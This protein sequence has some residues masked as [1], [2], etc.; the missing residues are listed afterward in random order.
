V[1]IQRIAVDR[2]MGRKFDIQVT[3]PCLCLCGPIGAGK[4]TVLH[5]VHLVL[6]LPTA[7][8]ERNLDRLSPSGAWSAALDFADG[9]VRQIRRAQRGA[10]GTYEVNGRAVAKTVWLDAVKQV[11]DVEPHHVSLDAFLGLSGQK[12]AALFAQLLEGGGAARACLGDVAQGVENRDLEPLVRSLVDEDEKA[13]SDLMRS[14]QPIV[15]TPAEVGEAMRQL[16]A[17]LAQRE[18]DARIH[19]DQLI[20]SRTSTQGQ[21]PADLQRLIAA[22]DEQLGKVKGEKGNLERDR[23]RSQSAH[24]VL[25]TAEKTLEKTKVELA[26]NR[27]IVEQAATRRSHVEAAE[28][29]HAALESELKAL[30][31]RVVPTSEA[32]RACQS[33]IDLLS[34]NQRIV[35]D[36]LALEWKVADDWI[37]AQAEEMLAAADVVQIQAVP[38]TESLIAF[39]RE[40]V[41]EVFGGSVEKIDEAIKEEQGRLEEA[42]A[43]NTALAQDLEAKRKSID[44]AA[45]DRKKAGKEVEELEQAEK[46]VVDL[47]KQVAER[48]DERAQLEKKVAETAVPSDEGVLDAQLEQV[49]GERDRLARLLRDA[50][51]A[52]ALSGQVENQRVEVERL[53]LMGTAAKRLVEMVHEWRNRIVTEQ[54]A[55]VMQPFRD[56][57]ETVWGQDMQVAHHSSGTGRSTEFEFTIDRGGAQV[58]LDLLSDGETTLTGAAF[59]TA[60]QRIHNG[61]GSILTMNTEALDAEGLVRLLQAAPDLGL[62]FVALANNRVR[63]DLSDMPIGLHG[64]EEVYGQWQFVDLG[65]SAKV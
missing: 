64:A 2:L 58:P 37:Y 31:D 49:K 1:N 46:A 10:K 35:S 3:K 53:E 11:L 16:S 48:E 61:V 20:D 23:E 17:H 4:S 36:L 42:E 33:K 60:L 19:L 29:T 38:P 14:L 63:E 45:T 6:G 27:A 15:G 43:E 39:A 26:R 50:E 21:S 24:D 54:V 34:A 40:V 30:T 18:R 22:Q 8:G 59:L 47:E 9:D 55:D 57:F 52:L 51:E 44:A 32:W 25:K 13:T 62:D 12:R 41:T 7:L 65:V 56:A 28:S 5:A